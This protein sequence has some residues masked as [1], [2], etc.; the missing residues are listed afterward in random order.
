VK[1]RVLMFGGDEPL[2]RIRAKVL[3]TI[4]CDTKVV[5]SEEQADEG[6]GPNEPKPQLVILCH[7]AE[8]DIADR[9][10]TTAQKA[11]IPT[12]SVERLIPPQQLLDDVS[13]VLRR[14]K[15]GSKA[16]KARP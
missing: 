6:M 4:G 14:G 3:S 2:L 8:D 7:S 12:Y 9:L 15:T 16:A 1:V 10:R 11:G 5:F 13:R